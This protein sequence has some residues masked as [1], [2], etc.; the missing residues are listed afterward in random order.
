MYGDKDRVPNAVLRMFESMK[1]ASDETVRA[2]EQRCKSMWRE[3]DWSGCPERYLYDYVWAGLRPGI[4]S[5]IK[6]HVTREDNRFESLAEL[7]TRAA[8]ADTIRSNQQKQQQKQTAQAGAATSTSTPS[9]Q[10]KPTEKGKKRPFRPSI[11]SGSTATA[12]TT[13]SSATATKHRKPRAV[14]RNKAEYEQLRAEGRCVR[15]ES[16]D[17]QTVQCPV[18]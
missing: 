12:A 7:F 18:Y 3:A 5:R 15:C 16:K 17:H 14:W 6:Q 8:A 4:I 9:D 10:P 1:Q 11:S 13:P 2:Y